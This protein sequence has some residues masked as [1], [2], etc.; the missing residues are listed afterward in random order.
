MSL[1]LNQVVEIPGSAAHNSLSKCACQGSTLKPVV[2]IPGSTVHVTGKRLSEDDFDMGHHASRDRVYL[3][4]TDVPK[5][6]CT[7]RVSMA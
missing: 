5:I 3:G 1:T 4:D 7:Y 2:G 6:V